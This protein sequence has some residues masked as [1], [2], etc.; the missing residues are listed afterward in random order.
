[1]AIGKY[2]VDQGSPLGEVHGPEG[3]L[4]GIRPFTSAFSEGH[5][6]V[7]LLIQLRTVQPA[8][9]RGELDGLA[10]ISQYNPHSVFIALEGSASWCS[11][12]RSRSSR[13]RWA[14]RGSSGPHAGCI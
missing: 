4:D 10:I 14:R 7:D 3:F 11:A 6:E 8:L 12:C 2:Y 9:V 1:M 5:S 13:F